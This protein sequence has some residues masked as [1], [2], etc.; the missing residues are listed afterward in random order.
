[1]ISDD[2]DDMVH[3]DLEDTSSLLPQRDPARRLQE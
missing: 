2:V 1:M 3:E